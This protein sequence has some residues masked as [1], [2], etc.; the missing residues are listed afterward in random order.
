MKWTRNGSRRGERPGA[1][2][3]R[4][5]R[6]SRDQ[7]GMT[8]IARRAWRSRIRR[9]GDGVASVAA[10]AL[11]CRLLAPPPGRARDRSCRVVRTTETRVAAPVAAL[12]VHQH[13][14]RAAADR[15][16]RS[17]RR[18]SQAVSRVTERLVRDR[19]LGRAPARRARLLPCS[20]SRAE[21]RS[22][23][24]APRAA[25]ATRV[26][27]FLS[28]RR[29]KRDAQN[30]SRRSAGEPSQPARPSTHAETRPCAG[31]RPPAVARRGSGCAPSRARQ[32]ARAGPR[33]ARWSPGAGR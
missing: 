14:H 30:E 13:L 32:M 3:E 33:D 1:V 6:A 28:R 31:R 9:R 23:R 29:R 10:L 24:A 20:R 17:C 15:P 4:R 26:R 16:R 21:D 11:A 7:E 12:S 5:V 27:R 8:M 2:R 18:R 25:R 19:W 22:P